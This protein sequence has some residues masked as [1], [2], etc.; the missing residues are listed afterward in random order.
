MATS[1]KAYGLNDSRDLL[2]TYAPTN[3]VDVPPYNFQTLIAS[4][5]IDSSQIKCAQ[6]FG[7]EV[8]AGCHNGDLLRFG[9]QMEDPNKVTIFS[10]HRV[11]FVLTKA[12]YSQKYTV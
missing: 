6:A 8:Y 4:T 9:L 1:E 10:S 12:Y 11:R 7:S 5:G 3:P 2:M